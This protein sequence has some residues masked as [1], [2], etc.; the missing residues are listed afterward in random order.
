MTSMANAKREFTFTGWHMLA[1]MFGFFGVIIAVNF[2]MA[3]FALSSWSGLVVEN[4]Y[5]ASQEFN[6]KAA[7]ARAWAETGIT[8]ELTAGAHGI[9][10]RVT[11]PKTGP[12][13]GER[14]VAQFRRPVGTAQDFTVTLTPQGNGLFV[15]DHVVGQGQWIVDLLTMDGDK[16]TYHEAIRIH[17]NGN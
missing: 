3:Y 6:G 4:T 2:T 5:V 10:Y 8:A 16:T 9:S 11:H 13:A 1:V 14:V 17:V 12:V 15:T 7:E